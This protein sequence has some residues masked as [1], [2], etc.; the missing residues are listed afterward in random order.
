MNYAA[1][2]AQALEQLDK[3][4]TKT[5]PRVLRRVM[6]ENEARE[7][8]KIVEQLLDVANAADRLLDRSIDLPEVARRETALRFALT[9]LKR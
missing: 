9:A 4:W 8:A 2:F 3:W 5:E 6:S 1:A 7:L